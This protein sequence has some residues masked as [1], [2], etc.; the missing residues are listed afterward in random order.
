MMF[1]DKSRNY[2]TDIQFSKR[3]PDGDNLVR[4]ICDICGFIDY[5][6]PKIVAG[7]VGVWGSKI[8]MCRRNI[9]PRK[10]FWTL[11]AG[12]MEQRETTQAAAAREAYEE[13]HAKIDIGELLGIYNVERISQ[14]QI[15]Y[16]GVL[17]TP[18]VRAGAESMEVALLEWD[19]VP[20]DQ[21]AFPSIYWALQ[22]FKQ[23]QGL[24]Y[25]PPATEPD[26]W[27]QTPGF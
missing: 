1:R 23:T 24:D 18:S 15:F 2:D 12:F 11:P 5:Q 7:V 20:W 8:L 10:G 21:L 6:N 27:S 25:F 26:D 17:K 4:D 19:E 13:A 14:V 3:E 22:Y 16:R 9:E